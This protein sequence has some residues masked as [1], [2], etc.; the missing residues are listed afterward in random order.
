VFANPARD[1]IAFREFLLG[2]NACLTFGDFL[3]RLEYLFGS[4]PQ[5]REVLFP[6]DLFMISVS[7]SS[8]FLCDRNAL[9]VRW[10]VKSSSLFSRSSIPHSMFF[11][12]STPTRR[13]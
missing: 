7:E 1:F 4:C 2:V 8:F 6:S 3:A 13:S 11:H 10:L 9:L 5:D 12:L